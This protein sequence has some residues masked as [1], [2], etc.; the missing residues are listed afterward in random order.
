MH[1]SRKPRFFHL[2]LGSA[3]A[4]AALALCAP[5]QARELHNNGVPGV[6][7]SVSSHDQ[8]GPANNGIPGV[9]MNVSS[10]DKG[11]PSN[12]GVPGIDVNANPTTT[13]TDTANLGAGNASTNG[14]ATRHGRR[15]DR[16]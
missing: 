13:T 10:Q 3:A 15:A 7:V 2:A 8:N 12:N 4:A 1:A 9:D 16:G 5:V 6:D 11:S 14:H